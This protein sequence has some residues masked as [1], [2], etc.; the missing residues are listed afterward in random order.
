[1][2]SGCVLGMCSECVRNVFGVFLGC[3]RDVFG[4]FSGC[5]RDVFGDVLGMIFCM[6]LGL[7]QPGL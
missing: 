6:F 7:S 4:M 1:M 5:F 2:F 3:L